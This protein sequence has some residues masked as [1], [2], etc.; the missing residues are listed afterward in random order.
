ML[1]SDDTRNAIKVCQD[2]GAIVTQTED[3]ITV[4]SHGLPLQT[5]AKQINT[6][7]S[8]ITTRFIMPILGLRHLAQQP[9]I[10]DC[11]EQMRARP[12]RSLVAALTTLE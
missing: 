2:L 10:L 9:I 12:I 5:A 6:G 11:N 7:N 8:G 4:Q 1:A 3:I